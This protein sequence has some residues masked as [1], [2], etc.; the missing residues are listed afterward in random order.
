MEG[1]IKN[2]DPL[3]EKGGGR[4]LKNYRQKR[5]FSTSST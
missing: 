5:G 4:L 1:H 2:I 3:P